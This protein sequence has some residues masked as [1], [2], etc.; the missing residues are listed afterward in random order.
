MY[1]KKHNEDYAKHKQS[2]IFFET[3]ALRNFMYQLNDQS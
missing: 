2:V 1:I 3:H